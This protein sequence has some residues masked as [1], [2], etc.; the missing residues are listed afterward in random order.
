MDSTEAAQDQVDGTALALAAQDA[1]I[2][3]LDSKLQAKDAQIDQLT[4][5]WPRPPYKRLRRGPGGRFGVSAKA[6]TTPSKALPHRARGGDTPLG[7]H[8]SYQTLARQ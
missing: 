6:S 5:S 3:S 4:G 7:N 2:A 1:R 8:F